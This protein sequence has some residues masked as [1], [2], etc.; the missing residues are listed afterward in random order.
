MPSEAATTLGGDFDLF[1][2][3]MRLLASAAPAQ[4]AAE[5][6]L[7]GTP[8]AAAAT[9]PA[10]P[11]PPAPCTAPVGRL[12][13]PDGVQQTEEVVLPG[14]Q[15]A[16]ADRRP[17]T[18]GG[19]RKHPLNH[20][21]RTSPG[22]HHHLE[23]ATGTATWPW[24]DLRPEGAQILLLNCAFFWAQIAR[25][26]RLS[27][28]PWAPYKKGPYAYAPWGP[29]AALQAHAHAHAHVHVHVLDGPPHTNCGPRSWQSP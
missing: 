10:R 17:G 22:L 20:H 2:N 13:Q 28:P 3:P 4:W 6:T 18:L 14:D 1:E 29:G 23:L 11:S 5:G 8:A 25:K 16:R 9:A 19:C 24:P 12:C 21:S 26:F 15:N 7:E 27:D